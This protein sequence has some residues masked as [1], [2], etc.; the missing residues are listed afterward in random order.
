VLRHDFC[1][2][3]ID[4]T[5]VLAGQLGFD[6]DL[7][8]GHSQR[9]HLHIDAGVVHLGQPVFGEIRQPPLIPF[10]AFG[11]EPKRQPR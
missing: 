7:Q 8:T 11:L 9:Q 10:G 4:E 2:I 6:V 5:S 1:D 3:V